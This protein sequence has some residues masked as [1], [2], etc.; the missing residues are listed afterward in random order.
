MKEMEGLEIIGL[1]L[2]RT[3]LETITEPTIPVIIFV[4]HEDTSMVEEVGMIGIL[5]VMEEEDILEIIKAIL[6]WA[7][8]VI[9]EDM[10]EQMK[11]M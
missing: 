7:L 2:D 11:V 6:V 1:I 9:I 5:E 10:P 8:E 3:I 4:P